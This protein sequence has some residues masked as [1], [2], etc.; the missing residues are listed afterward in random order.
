MVESSRPASRHSARFL[1]LACIPLAGCSVSRIEREFVI[2]MQ[3]VHGLDMWSQTKAMTFDIDVEFGGRPMLDA[4]FVFETNGPRVRMETPD[5]AVCTFDGNDAW[6]SPPSAATPM[7][8][9]HLLTWPWFLYCPMKLQGEGVKLS[10][11]G[12]M[13]HDGTA[14]TTVKMTFDP[15]TG[16]APDDRYI[17]YKDPET[18]LLALQGY[19]VTY[20]KAVEEANK[21]PHAITYIHY[22]DVG[23]VMLSTEWRFWAWSPS[24]GVTG[25]P[26]GKARLSNLRFMVPDDNTFAAPPDASS[27]SLP[28]G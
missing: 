9:F 3:K 1:L 27:L 5:G 16:D 2:P 13:H 18:D 4:S 10:S 28:S 11:L 25:D 8:R 12:Q 19:I 22:N 21:D 23:G 26:I 24:E 7:S 15:G 6:I 14:H 17:L 20:G